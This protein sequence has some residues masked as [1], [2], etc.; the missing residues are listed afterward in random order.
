MEVRSLVLFRDNAS[1]ACNSPQAQS[2]LVKEL[3]L[4]RLFTILRR[5][6]ARLVVEQTFQIAWSAQT[7][8]LAQSAM[9]LSSS[10]SMVS[11]LAKVA[12]THYMMPKTTLVGVRTTTT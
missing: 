12:R 7:L 4:A 11:A 2:A 5:K 6:N 8:K 10:L 9:G 1:T 3:H